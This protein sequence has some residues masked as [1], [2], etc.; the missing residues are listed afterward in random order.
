[1]QNITADSYDEIADIQG[2]T[3]YQLA[4]DAGKTPT[5][6]LAE[7]NAHNRDKSR[8][9]MQWDGT[10]NVGFTTG[11]PWIKVNED[12]AT[13]NVQE[14]SLRKNSILNTYKALLALRNNEQVLQ[15]GSYKKLE[16]QG[17]MILFT[18]SYK[19]VEIT[20]LLN[21]GKEKDIKLPN[22]AKILMGNTT[23]KS[24]GFLIYKTSLHKTNTSE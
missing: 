7:G 12:Y 11:K 19:G 8:S 14:S 18:R 20:V 6:A 13:V 17:D 2:K 1:M 22:S 23:L 15:Y 9:P 10:V 24:N 4:I 21:F 16:R 3:F 5:E